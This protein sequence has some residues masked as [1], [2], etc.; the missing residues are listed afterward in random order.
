[1][2]VRAGVRIHPS[3]KINGT[4]RIH[5]TNAIIGAQTWLGAGSQII[6]TRNATVEI[7]ECCDIGPEAMFVTGTH[8]LGG[9][10]RRAGTGAAAS[11][12]I[13]DGSWIGARATFTAGA[14]VGSGC[15]VAAGSLVRDEFPDNVMIAGV[16]ARI[17]RH[18]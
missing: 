3:A 18:L 10:K 4:A 6:P 12:I 15:V 1:M 5:G 8:E 14:S 11:I 16:P 2:Y 7:G 13:G 17:V 9:D